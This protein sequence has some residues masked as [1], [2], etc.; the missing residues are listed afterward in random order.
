MRNI[1]I[2]Y[3]IHS[4]FITLRWKTMCKFILRKH[5]LLMK[6]FL[7]NTW[8]VVVL[9]EALNVCKGPCS[10]LHFPQHHTARGWHVT[11]S[12][13]AT[14]AEMMGQ[15]QGQLVLANLDFST[16]PFLRL[17]MRPPKWLCWLQLRS[18]LGLC[19]TTFS[20]HRTMEEA[21]V[22]LCCVKP[23]RFH[24]ASDCCSCCYYT[25]AYIFF[26]ISIGLPRWLSDESIH[27]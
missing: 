27:R 24:I 22:N 21:K 13:R 23:L 20:P 26:I 12:S 2:D 4:N 8:H 7:L 5:G 9:A 25:I 14:Q 11:L 15:F 17:E 1:S 16:L 10:G 18:N 6:I 3:R 19:F